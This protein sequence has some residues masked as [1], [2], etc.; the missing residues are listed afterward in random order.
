MEK[1]RVEMTNFINEMINLDF[2]YEEKKMYVIDRMDLIEREDDVIF[3]QKERE[4][5]LKI[6]KDAYFVR[7]KNE[8]E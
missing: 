6:L 3:S 7:R 8:K 2:T 1:Y 5:Y 4:E